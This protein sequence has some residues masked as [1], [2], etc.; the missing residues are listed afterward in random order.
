V[1]GNASN[2]RSVNRK[3]ARGVQR[4]ARPT[5]LLVLLGSVRRVT[6]C[7]PFS[8][9]CLTDG[10]LGIRLSTAFLAVEELEAQ[11]HLVAVAE[12]AAPARPE[13]STSAE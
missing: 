13:T 10:P 12:L 8:R 11:A 4:T 6:P 5:A 3:V 9:A 2:S 1:R 7:V